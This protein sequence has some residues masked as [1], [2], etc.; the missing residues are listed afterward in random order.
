MKG[1]VVVENGRRH[2]RW[3]S[4]GNMGRL[5]VKRVPQTLTIQEGKLLLLEK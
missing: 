2:K 4:G 3:G 5:L 1:V